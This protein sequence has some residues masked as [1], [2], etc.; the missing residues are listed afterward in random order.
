M[1]HEADATRKY[2]GL[3]QNSLGYRRVT[4]RTSGSDDAIMA[5]GSPLD[6]P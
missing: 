3:I 1:K 5:V 6:Q 2:V 4:G